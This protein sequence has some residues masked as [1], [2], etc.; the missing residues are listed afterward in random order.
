[1]MKGC[2]LILFLVNTITAKPVENKDKKDN[3]TETSDVVCTYLL[4]IPFSNKTFDKNVDELMQ[5]RKETIIVTFEP[6]PS[7]F[8]GSTG[9]PNGRP[10]TVHF[11]WLN[12]RKDLDGP[13]QGHGVLLKSGPK[14]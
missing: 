7:K 12:V 14:L 10:I 8:F 13:G 1:M 3:I 2:V 9:F 4:T 5:N 11:Y 6:R